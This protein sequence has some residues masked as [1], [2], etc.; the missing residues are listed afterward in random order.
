MSEHRPLFFSAPAL[1]GQARLKH[2]QSCIRDY[3]DLFA[4]MRTAKRI[5][6][7]ITM[8]AD[9]SW[10]YG[11]NPKAATTTTYAALFE[12][13][14]GVKL[15]AHMDEG[16][17]DW[18][19]QSPQN[20]DVAQFIYQLDE[21]EGGIAAMRN[22][23]RFSVVRNPVERAASSFH[24]ICYTQKKSLRQFYADR[25]RMNAMG[26]DWEADAYTERGFEKFMNYV[27]FEAQ[28]TRATGRLPDPHFRP[29]AMNMCLEA[30]DPHLVFR[31][32]DLAEGLRV[33]AT[34]LGRPP[35]AE[36]TSAARLNA[37]PERRIYT[38]HSALIERVYAQDFDIY[39]SASCE[40]RKDWI[41]PDKAG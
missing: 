16:L 8:P 35:L 11:T 27:E 31:V 18:A 6:Q 17:A 13:T 32:D 21:F 41:I 20:M 5:M 4:D 37:Q 1:K 14:S 33:L 10:A 12:L 34:Q 40:L 36:K 24:F 19:D 39:E 26:F 29:Q 15:S 38:S 3:P 7:R 2:M 25:V 9:G 30:L 22:A 23:F 28:D